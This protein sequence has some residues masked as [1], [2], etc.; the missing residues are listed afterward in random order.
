MYNYIY[1][2]PSQDLKR[3]QTLDIWFQISNV[4]G[5]YYLS[6]RNAW[7]G[8]SYYFILYFQIYDTY[9]VSWFLASRETYSTSKFRKMWINKTIMNQ[10]FPRSYVLCRSPPSVNERG[11][12]IGSDTF[13][14]QCHSFEGFFRMVNHLGYGLYLK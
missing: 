11:P 8:P 13:T 1:L 4:I 2:F 14:Y 5:Q 6:H 7:K 10:N 3:V 12:I 9:L